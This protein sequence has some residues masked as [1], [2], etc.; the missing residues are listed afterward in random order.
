MPNLSGQD[1]FDDAQVEN[2]LLLL[3]LIEK[4]DIP[5]S[6]GQISQ[7]AIQENVMDFFTLQQTL[8]DMVAS[9]YLEKAVQD[10]NTY[11]SMTEEGS[12]T[13]EYFARRISEPIHA[14]ISQ[15]VSENRKTI[16]RDYEITANYF[17]EHSS[18][19]FIV[20]CGLYDDETT[21]M[22]INISV[23]TREQAKMICSNWRGH[24]NKLY[25]NIL[26]E[27]VRTREEEE[28]PEQTSGSTPI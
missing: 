10:N 14:K 13:L 27:L 6:N 22:E 20:K 1:T 19:E 7:F 23:V 18:N 25:R 26:A 9:G 2:K 15:Y 24:V 28:T 21:L 5:L 8:A 4:M 17:Y 16:K 11:Y 3:Y 12:T